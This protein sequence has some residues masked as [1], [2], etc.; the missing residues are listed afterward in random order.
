MDKQ[1]GHWV[2]LFTLVGII[3]GFALAVLIQPS[4]A[5]AQSVAAQPDFQSR[6]LET[7]SISNLQTFVS[8][9]SASPTGH[10]F[11][12][13]GVLRQFGQPVTAICDFQF[14]LWNDLA[15]GQQVGI[16]QSI[17]A[18]QVSNGLFNAVLNSGSEFGTSVFSGQALWIEIKVRCPSVTGLYTLLSPRQALN[19]APLASGLAP[20]GALQ[21]DG[22]ELNNPAFS[23][24]ASTAVN[25]RP[26]GLKVVAGSSTAVSIPGTPTGIFVQSG[27]G[28]GLW[29]DTTTGT[30]VYA[31]SGGAGYAG[32]FDG[33]VRVT[34][35]VVTD[36][37]T[38]AAFWIES[39]VQ[40]YGPLPITKPGYVST[41]GGDLMLFFSGSGYSA[42]AGKWIG[43]RVLLDS[44]EVAST[45]VYA[46]N[47]LM[48]LS[49]VT[50]NVIIKGLVAGTH[51][52]SLQAS[53]GTST[54]A[55]DL[56]FVSALEIPK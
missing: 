24:F 6:T 8:A 50:G 13:Q 11:T 22:S 31:K 17:P 7:D 1:N 55:T 20:F 23:I 19:A 49:F 44:S 21:A 14:L 52:I 29:A 40:Q 9:P 48:H 53:T 37:I 39:W 43:M 35:L 42:T 45:G 12:Y 33:A 46:N 32:D 5:T 47:A 36:K 3:C 38:S 28:R 16:T 26:V 51:T 54:D 30:A 41:G 2:V 34:D 18:V 4:S 10:S 15:A 25:N 56:F 27:E